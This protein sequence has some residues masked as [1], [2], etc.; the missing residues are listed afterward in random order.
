MV[1]RGTGFDTNQARRQILEKGQD[2]TP[3]QLPA[4]DHLAT[5]VNAVDLEYRLGNVETDCRD[6]LHG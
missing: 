5:G 6:R 4:D 2:V 3:L 1:C